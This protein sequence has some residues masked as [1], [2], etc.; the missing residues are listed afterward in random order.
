MLLFPTIEKM[1]QSPQG[2][3][4]TPLLRNMK[5]L[6]MLIAGIKLRFCKVTAYSAIWVLVLTF[7]L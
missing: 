4:L 3:W 1:A 2:R 5:W 7:S 6:F